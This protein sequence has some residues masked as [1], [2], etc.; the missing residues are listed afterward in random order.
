MKTSKHS[1]E[2]KTSRAQ[3]KVTFCITLYCKKVFFASQKNEFEIKL[4]MQKKEMKR[5]KVVKGNSMSLLWKTLTCK[6]KLT[7]PTNARI[8]IKERVKPFYF[9]SVSLPLIACV[10]NKF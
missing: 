8:R 4:V 7:P 10:L 1:V 9:E 2:S 5:G 3:S 6:I